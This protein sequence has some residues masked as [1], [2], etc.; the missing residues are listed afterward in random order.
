MSK[1]F[2]RFLPRIE[3]SGLRTVRID[4]NIALTF[5]DSKDN[6]LTVSNQH[7][8]IDIGERLLVYRYYDFYRVLVKN[9]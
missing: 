7:I 2:N 5:F 4:D 6:I 3:R 9:S 1:L 8:N